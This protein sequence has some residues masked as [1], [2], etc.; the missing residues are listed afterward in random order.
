VTYSAR[1]TTRFWD[2]FPHPPGDSAPF[3]RDTDDPDGGG[4]VALHVLSSA[5]PAAPRV[6][7]VVP[8][9]GWDTSTPA[10]G[11]SMTTRRGGGLRVYLDRPWYSSGEGELLGVVHMKPG[12]SPN[13]S[14]VPNELQP[15]VTQWGMD[16]LYLDASPFNT[17]PGN[18]PTTG[19]FRHVA[20]AHPD[21]PL[22][23][24]PELRVAVAGYTPEYDPDRRLW[25]CDIELAAGHT[26]WP[27]VRLAL[28][29]FQ[30][31]AV[32]GAH[33]SRVVLADFVQLAPDRTA[34]FRQFIT[35][36]QPS[37]REYAVDVTVT[38]PGYDSSS[39]GAGSSVM[40]VTL[41]QQR[42]GISGDLS[43]FDLGESV[44]VRSTTVSG[45]DVAW[46]GT[47]FLPGPFGSAP[48][49]LV[50]REYERIRGDADHLSGAGGETTQQRLVYVSTY[51]IPAA[52]GAAP[53]TP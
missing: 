25:Y 18:V 7:Y 10:P 17:L 42:P 13:P 8:T 51:V 11:K 37:E 21:L 20:G 26:Y 12:A 4:P 45:P 49:R 44:L 35:G 30:P 47:V 31:H 40:R 15:Y 50:V 48:Y 9:F 14:E 2:D 34:T 16:P 33:L 19:V 53:A 22:S 29:R 43:W 24:R 28:A 41:Q 52:A 5:P 1:T 27:F 36:G 39:A 38:G 32:P 6:L 46:S 3:W 23:E